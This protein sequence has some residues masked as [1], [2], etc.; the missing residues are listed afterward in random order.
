M[1]EYARAKGVSAKLREALESVI[2]LSRENG[3]SETVEYCEKVPHTSGRPHVDLV[4]GRNGT[5]TRLTHA[6]T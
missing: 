1:K 4:L 6:D 2:D 3:V 5:G